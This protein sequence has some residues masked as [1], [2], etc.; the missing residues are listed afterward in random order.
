VKFKDY[1]SER[2]VK[3]D[4]SEYTIDL[5][6]YKELYEASVGMSKQL[7]Q[8]RMNIHHGTGDI[9]I[10][11]ENAFYMMNLSN[12]KVSPIKKRKQKELCGVL[13]NGL[14]NKNNMDE[15]LV[16]LIKESVNWDL[17]SDLVFKS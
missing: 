9:P 14:L 7:K 12:S 17:P 15:K 11:L 6:E 4:G 8:L 2:V 13:I 3:V 16:E 5:N 10:F 1:I